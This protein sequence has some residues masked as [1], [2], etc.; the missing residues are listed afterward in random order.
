M[1]TRAQEVQNYLL[2]EGLVPLNFDQPTPTS[3]MAAQAIG[4]SVGEIAK[5]LLMLVGKA[6]LLVV[7]SGD[8]KIKSGRLKQACGLAGKVRLPQADEVLQYTGYNPGA[9]SPFL[10]PKELPVLL[11]RSLQRYQVIYPAAATSRSGWR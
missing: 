1:D 9:V 8:T 4:C 7:T 3:A 5:S 11:D 2:R 6:P 10:L